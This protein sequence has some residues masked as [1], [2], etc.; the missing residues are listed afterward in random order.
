VVEGVIGNEA[1]LGDRSHYYITV[2]GTERRI[3]V[4]YQNMTRSL[5]NSDVRGRTVWLS[6][7]IESAVL[8]PTEPRA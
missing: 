6:W 4:A 1:Y 7:P 3:A 5:D 2:K 8:L